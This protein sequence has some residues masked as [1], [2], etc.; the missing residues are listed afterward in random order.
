MPLSPVS[1]SIKKKETKFGGKDS[2]AG[3]CLQIGDV[4]AAFYDSSKLHMT[5]LC[6][7]SQGCVVLDCI[8][9]ITF[10][11]ARPTHP[12]FMSCSVSSS[13]IRTWM[14]L[15]SRIQWKMSSILSSLSSSY[16]ISWSSLSGSRWKM[17]RCWGARCCLQRPTRQPWDPLTTFLSRHPNPP[18]PPPP[19][20]LACSLS[21]CCPLI[22]SLTPLPS[23]SNQVLSRQVGRRALKGQGSEKL[24]ERSRS[25]WPQTHTEE[26]RDER[27]LAATGGTLHTHTHF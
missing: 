24:S 8:T 12:W 3:V 16:P 22:S 25:C 9:Q 15:P 17:A 20:S 2:G 5:P 21:Y 23:A 1:Y 13:H 27:R 7:T 10:G 19:P 18:P 11:A 26:R 4:A 14:V 6:V